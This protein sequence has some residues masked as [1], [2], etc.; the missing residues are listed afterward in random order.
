MYV[1]PYPPLNHKVLIRMTVNLRGNSRT[2]RQAQL[3]SVGMIKVL[4][5]GFNIEG[6]GKHP[7]TATNHRRSKSSA[8]LYDEQSVAKAGTHFHGKHTGR[9]LAT[10]I[11]K[12]GSREYLQSLGVLAEDS[13][14][15]E[16]EG[17]EVSPTATS[18]VGATHQLNLGH[19]TPAPHTDDESEL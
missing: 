15:E 14:D 4:V 18:Q 11:F 17:D 7:K 6:K 19:D 12:Y 1:S 16:L 9:P 10:F 3:L 5:R 8:T 2:N 13:S